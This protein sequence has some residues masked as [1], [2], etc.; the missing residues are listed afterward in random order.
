MI[1]KPDDRHL[2]IP[3]FRYATDWSI[4]HHSAWLVAVSHSRTP[5]SST[6]LGR[7]GFNRPTRSITMISQ[8]GCQG[9]TR[10]ATM[11]PLSNG[12]WAGSR[13]LTKNAWSYRS[14]TSLFTMAFMSEKSRTM[15]SFGCPG[16]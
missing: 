1:R 12:T 6:S 4:A 14:S 2:L 7:H 13:S 8:D 16:S 9:A 15:P 5:T 10:T 11:G 3:V